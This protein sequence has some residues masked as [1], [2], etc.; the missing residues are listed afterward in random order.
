MLALSSGLVLG[1][2]NKAAPPASDL[3]SGGSSAGAARP[4]VT[5]AADPVLTREEVAAVLGQ[6]VTTIDGKGMN[7]TYK[8]DVLGLEAAV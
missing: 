7:L 1:G 4:A 3:P 8:T 2:C 6:P 5:G